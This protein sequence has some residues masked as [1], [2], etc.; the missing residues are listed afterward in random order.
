MIL[1]IPEGHGCAYSIDTEGEL[2][3]TPICAGDTL[4]LEETAS[5][6]Y[7]DLYGGCFEP[8]LQEVHDKLIQLNKVAGFYFKN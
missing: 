5:V 7:D 2:F 6:D 8:E 4:Y 1:Y 3:Y